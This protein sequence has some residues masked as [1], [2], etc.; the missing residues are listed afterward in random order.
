MNFFYSVLAGKLLKHSTILKN[1]T[2]V[3]LEASF[4]SNVFN[5]Q[6]K[7]I[8]ICMSYTIILYSYTIYKLYKCIILTCIVLQKIQY[9]QK[10]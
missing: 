5:L 7:Q 9:C 8:I 4:Y 1:L 6:S 2:Q 3:I 10:E